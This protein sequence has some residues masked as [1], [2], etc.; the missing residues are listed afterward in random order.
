[1]RS[2][3]VAGAILA[4]GLSFDEIIVTTFTAGPGIS[5]LPIWIYENL[6]RPNQAPIVNVVAAALVLISILPIYI[7]QRFSNADERGGGLI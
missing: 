4:F 5:T 2:A 1:M 6:F 7:A 3:L